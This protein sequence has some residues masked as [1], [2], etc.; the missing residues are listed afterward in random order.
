MTSWP[1]RMTSSEIAARKLDFQKCSLPEGVVPMLLHLQIGHPPHV[2]D[3][4][5]PK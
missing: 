2:L 3:D 1:M 4:G 5:A